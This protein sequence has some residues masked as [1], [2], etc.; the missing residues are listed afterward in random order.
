MHAN[1]RMVILY[2]L[3]ANE[4]AISP[5]ILSLSKAT[6]L[7]FQTFEQTLDGVGKSLVRSNLRN[8]CRVATA[9]GHTEQCKQG[10]TRRLAFVRHV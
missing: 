3:S 8:P 5:G 6:V 7:G 4:L 10:Q 9:C 2:R 1:N